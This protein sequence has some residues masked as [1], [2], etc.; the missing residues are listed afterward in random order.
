M[1][2]LHLTVNCHQPRGNAW[3][4]N[5][6]SSQFQRKHWS[7]GTWW[8][9]EVRKEVSKFTDFSCLYANDVHLEGFVVGFLVFLLGDV[10]PFPSFVGMM[11]E[12]QWN[13]RI[14]VWC[15]IF[16]YI[17]NKH[18]LNVGDIP[19][20]DPMGWVVDR[21]FYFFQV[22]RLL[23]QYNVPRCE[24]FLW[25]SGSKDGLY[26]YVVVKCEYKMMNIN[27]LWI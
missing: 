10:N 23:W 6:R 26:M 22:A 20:I 25:Q 11:S 17:A 4:S 5:F 8:D 21:S 18:Q 16:S 12:I 19:Y 14:N 7:L 3:S 9:H 27:T 1:E 24:F 15:C 13:V 2:A